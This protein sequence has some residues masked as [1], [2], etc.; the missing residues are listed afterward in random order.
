EAKGENAFFQLTVA[1][2]PIFDP[3]PPLISD[4]E[5]DDPLIIIIT[6]ILAFLIFCMVLIILFLLVALILLRWRAGKWLA[7]ANSAEKEVLLA[8][9]WDDAEAREWRNPEDDNSDY[10]SAEEDSSSDSD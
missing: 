10:D 7:L 3:P 9:V 6:A 8:E 2:C 5:S 1:R 4:D